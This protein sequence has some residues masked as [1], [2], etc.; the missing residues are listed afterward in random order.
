MK[1]I[2]VFLFDWDQFH[3]ELWLQVHHM[4]KAAPVAL[5]DARNIFPSGYCW[6]F[7]RGKN[8]LAATSTMNVVNV[9]LST[10]PTNV[11]FQGEYEIQH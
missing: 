4:Q 9:D 8:V 11:P 5:S 1:K 2:S 6:K 3:W 7:H 10:Q